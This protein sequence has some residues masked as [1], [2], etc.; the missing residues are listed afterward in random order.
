M[1]FW[2]IF[3]NSSLAPP[4]V[5]SLLRTVSVTG[6]SPG[7]MTV[8]AFGS[9][10]PAVPFLTAVTVTSAKEGTIW[11]PTRPARGTVTDLFVVNF[12][13]FGVLTTLPAGIVLV[14][15]K[16]TLRNVT[17]PVAA[18]SSIRLPAVGNVSVISTGTSR[19]TAGTTALAVSTADASGLAVTVSGMGPIASCRGVTVISAAGRMKRA[20]MATTSSASTT[21]AAPTRTGVS[22]DMRP[23]AARAG[24]RPSVPRSVRGSGAGPGAEPVAPRAADPAPRT[25]PAGPATASAA[26]AAAPAAPAPP[27][28]APAAAAGVGQTLAWVSSAAAARRA[29]RL[30]LG[31]SGRLSPVGSTGATVGMTAGITASPASS[32]A[33]GGPARADSYSGT[34][35]NTGSPA[36]AA[37]ARVAGSPATI[38]S[39]RLLMTASRDSS[40]KF[41]RDVEIR[42]P[43]GTTRATLVESEERIREAAD[44]IS[45]STSR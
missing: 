9:T 6:S 25:A 32:A 21:A 1:S 4:V 5:A 10:F 44:V 39:L 7:G 13:P 16:S 17:V 24:R 30:V 22:T 14:A 28:T 15:V 29:R 26:P 40:R 27:A 2:S 23:T 18:V 41:I 11:R 12:V 31:G 42:E 33:A 20:P 37:S 8:I 34:V 38:D 43:Y 35:A 19:R 3:G 45:S 36:D